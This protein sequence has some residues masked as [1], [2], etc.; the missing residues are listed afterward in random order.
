MDPCTAETVASLKQI[1]G[2]VSVPCYPIIGNHEPWTPGG[3]QLFYQGLGLPKRGYYAVGRNG[4]RLLMLSTPTPGSLRRGSEQLRWLESQL[5]EASPTEDVVLFSH[6]SLRLHPCVSGPRNDGYQLLDNHSEIL[7]LL[8][9]FPN[10]R[11]F[12]AGH[13]NVPS[14]VPHRGIIHTLS[15]QLIQAPC[16]Y[17][18]LRLYE[19]GAAR[20]TYEIDEQHYCEVGR[21]AYDGDWRMRYGDDEGRNFCVAYPV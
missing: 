8:G 1:L 15:P 3:E 7:K 21:A 16:G 5:E 17:D 14:M 20:T 11:L 12:V 6:F 9:D 19:G 2:S 13:K 10:V 4:V 18:M